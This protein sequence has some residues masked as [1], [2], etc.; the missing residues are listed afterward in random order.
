MKNN[1]YNPLFESLLKKVNDYENPQ[2]ITEQDSA[3][4]GSKAIFSDYMKSISQ[5]GA[6]L[7]AQYANAVQTYPK[8]D[9]KAEYMKTFP[10]K[11][12]AMVS[13]IDDTKTP[14]IQLE[15]LFNTVKAEATAF[16]GLGAKEDKRLVKHLEPWRDSFRTGFQL[17]TQAF[18]SLMEYVKK[19]EVTNQAQ[20]GEE[21]KAMMKAAASKFVTSLVASFE[22][23][24]TI[25]DTKWGEPVIGESLS[26]GSVIEKL[27]QNKICVDFNTFNTVINE[28]KEDRVARRAAKAI[29]PQ[30]EALQANITNVLNQIGGRLGDPAKA[31]F[32]SLAM[33]PEFNKIANTLVSIQDELSVEK[34]ELKN[35]QFDDLNKQVENL[36]NLFNSKKESYDK[37]YAEEEKSLRSYKTLQVATPEVVK[38]IEDGDAQ[39]TALS[40]LAQNGAN[41]FSADLAKEKADKAQADKLK[42]ESQPKNPGKKDGEIQKGQDGFNYK[43]DAKAKVWNKVEE[44]DKPE[45]KPSD[46]K[47]AAPLKKGAKG[48]QVKAVQELIITKMAKKLA[49]DSEYKR[50]AKFGADG[51]FG[52]STA[53][54]IPLLKSGLG[55]TD[56]S[57]DMT[58]ELVDKLAAVK[59]SFVFE[60]EFDMDAYNKAKGSGGGGNS[61]PGKSSE[62][63][64]R[65]SPFSCI[66]KIEGGLTV[67]G[68]E[69]TLTRENG[70]IHTFKSDGTY[71]YYYVKEKKTQEGTWKCTADSFEAYTEED[72]D[73]YYGSLKDWKSNIDNA[74]K[75]KAEEAKK[76]AEALSAQAGDIC[77]EILINF[78]GD[79]EEEEA[80]M[81]IF[82]KKITTPEMF[83]AVQNFWDSK[84]WPSSAQLS[85][86]KVFFKNKSVEDITKFMDYKPGKSGQSLRRAVKNYFDNAQITRLNQYLPSGIKAI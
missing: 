20:I 6:K 16:F 47:L 80:I 64:T 70:N 66:K 29:R 42:G 79:T 62:T 1:I 7:I 38:F 73:T 63:E 18:K 61:S 72:K 27:I 25:T 36:V 10:D 46:I 85:K 52:N 43:W 34:A 21:G 58:Q 26:R 23:N 24:K 53:A 9:V 49:N 41:L 32:K 3:G 81:E 14:G 54:I 35:V 50:F 28:A 19:E 78:A 48:D 17:Y 82:Q 71:K 45:V 13:S 86:T 56:K 44:E 55:L 40:D 37:T 4:K 68:G 77:K 15:A 39:F 31:N 8:T 57:S 84:W 83:N 65:S 22:K 69:A 11:L 33:A 59:E 60:Q 12:N 5:L 75:K 74:E 67:K 30:I 76:A 2:G 51:K